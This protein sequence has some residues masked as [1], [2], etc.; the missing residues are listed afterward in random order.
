MGIFI[1]KNYKEN[2]QG[3]QSCHNRHLTLNEEFF[4]LTIVTQVIIIIKKKTSKARV[5]IKQQLKTELCY[6]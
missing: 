5:L 3:W 1:L 4:T 6:T 2:P